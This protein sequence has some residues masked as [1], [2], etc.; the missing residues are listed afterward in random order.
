MEIFI[1]SKDVRQGRRKEREKNKK[2]RI[3]DKKKRVDF[4]FEHFIC[5][6][7]NGKLL[8][9]FGGIWWKPNHKGVKNIKNFNTLA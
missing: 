5:G 3:V 7:L 4:S 1:L 2:K 6:P 8:H 9:F